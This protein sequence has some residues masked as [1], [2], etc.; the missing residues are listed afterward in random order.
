MPNNIF[1][2]MEDG[3]FRYICKPFALD[4]LIGAIDESLEYRKSRLASTNKTEVID[5]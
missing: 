3:L 4:V 5:G 2:E 1:K